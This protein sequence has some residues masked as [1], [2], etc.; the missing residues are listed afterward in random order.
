MKGKHVADRNRPTLEED[1]R[2][3]FLREPLENC[4]IDSAQLEQFRLGKEGYLAGLAHELAHA[5]QD[6]TV[7][8]SSFRRASSLD[9]K[10]AAHA[11]IE[12]D[13]E[14]MA[15]L[16]LARR[17]DV[18]PETAIQAQSYRLQYRALDA[19]EGA[20]NGITRL[21]PL[22]RELVLFLYV[23]GARL[24][25]GLWRAGGIAALDRA[26]ASPPPSSVAVL[27]PQPWLDGWFVPPAP[28]PPGAIASGSL[29][30]LLLRLFL[31]SCGG[32][33]QVERLAHAYRG[34]A[35][36][37]RPLPHPAGRQLIWSMRW[38]TPEAA[39]A[40]Q[41]QLEKCPNTTVTVAPEDQVLTW[42]LGDRLWFVQGGTPAE[43][44]AAVAAIRDDDE[45][46]PVAGP[47]PLGD[48]HIPPPDSSGLVPPTKTVEGHRWT[49]RNLGLSA[50]LP[51]GVTVRPTPG[52][53]LLLVK[54]GA[55]AF[56]E[57]VRTQVGPMLSPA[58][59]QQAVDQAWRGLEWACLEPAFSDSLPR[60]CPAVA[61][62]ANPVRSGAVHLG[63]AQGEELV[64]RLGLQTLRQ[65]V[66]PAC[67]GRA[68]FLFKAW[69]TDDAG[70]AVL[71]AWERSIRPLDAQALVCAR[72]TSSPVAAA[73][74]VT[75]VSEPGVA[76]A[77]EPEAAQLLQKACDGGAAAGCFYLALLYSKGE[78]VA[79]DAA[80]AAVLYQK[81]CDG[82]E[83]KA[84]FNLGGLYSE[85]EGVA[86]DAARAAVLYQ[87]ACDGGEWKGC[88][89]LG[90]LYGMARASRRTRPGRRCS[91][92]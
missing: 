44:E 56:V 50:P 20:P 17:R 60:S 30:A 52:I 37:V 31:E 55:G 7:S 78:G 65:R 28:S 72:A 64:E 73:G 75:A 42:R 27:H 32:G 18:S 16:V 1:R 24:A 71:D 76:S 35:Y 29:G 54:P 70:A 34:D 25:L 88:T 53:E 61:D 21:P 83:A 3:A 69:T 85:G 40:A 33:S 80:R 89:N 11:L 59:Q 2:V 36:V 57:S 26:L 41:K 82:G 87:K 23:D 4:P 81:A 58:E 68:V 86:K 47:R 6:E 90:L 22:A 12:G 46:R 15:L 43:R 13:A 5:L 9:A 48:V 74:P 45:L 51:D 39:I 10:L 77:R 14:V 92:G 67:G 8:M 63:W 62:R 49:S 38:A 84:C 79:K 91:T 66:L 19:K